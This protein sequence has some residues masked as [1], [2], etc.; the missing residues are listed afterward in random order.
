[1]QIASTGTYGGRAASPEV[2]FFTDDGS[3]AQRHPSSASSSAWPRSIDPNSSCGSRS[4][5]APSDGAS[6]R[7]R[8]RR[9]ED[10][11]VRAQR[12]RSFGGALGRPPH[13][14]T[15]SGAVDHGA[16]T[17]FVPERRRGPVASPHDRCARSIRQ[18]SLSH[19]D[20]P[21]PR[22]ATALGHAAERRSLRTGD[23]PRAA[24]STRSPRIPR[25]GMGR[26]RASHRPGAR[27][28]ASL[29]R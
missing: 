17:R 27:R 11:A 1:V 22:A 23:A 28:R 15:D 24:L 14:T 19:A 16:H 7:D 2:T 29:C 18:S 26:A 10:G 13:L 25:C 21:P 20:R 3:C 4:D 9:D 8:A 12:S 5:R 6:K